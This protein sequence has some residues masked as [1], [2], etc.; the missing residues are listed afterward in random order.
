MTSFI[1]EAI[2]FTIANYAVTFFCAG[3]EGVMYFW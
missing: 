3:L 1:G 2:R